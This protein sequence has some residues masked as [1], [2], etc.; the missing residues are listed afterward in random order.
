M[1]SPLPR[2]DMPPLQFDV[3]ATPTVL[4]IRIGGEVDL[5]NTIE[6][7]SKLATTQP[8]GHDAVRVDLGCLAFCDVKGAWLILEFIKRADR[9]KQRTTV[10]GAT[11]MVRKLLTLLA[12]GERPAFD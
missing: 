7:H 1:D 9:E 10:G 2:E 3:T 5:S 11:P 12:D 6:L 8:D 4:E